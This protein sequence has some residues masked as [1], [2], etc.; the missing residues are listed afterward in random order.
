ML[1]V[2]SSLF[3][4]VILLNVVILNVFMLSVVMLSVVYA[5]C[6]G[7]NF[8]S[9]HKIDEALDTIKIVSE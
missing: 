1:G 3:C 8:S 7:T 9:G 4:S 6:R 5:G 2:S